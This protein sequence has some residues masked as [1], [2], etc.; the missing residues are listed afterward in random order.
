MDDCKLDLVVPI[1][2]G[3]RQIK[4]QFYENLLGE[5]I[6]YKKQTKKSTNRNNHKKSN[7]QY[8]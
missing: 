1:S 4:K 3:L 6:Y 2:E 5:N 7:N 8:K